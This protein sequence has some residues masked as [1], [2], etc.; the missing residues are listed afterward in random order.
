MQPKTIASNYEVSNDDDF[1]TSE[2]EEANMDD[3]L[4]LQTIIVTESLTTVQIK[5]TSSK[6]MSPILKECYV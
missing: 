2:L 1:Q 3:C 5:S 4:L 6:G